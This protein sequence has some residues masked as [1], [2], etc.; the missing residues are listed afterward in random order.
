[1][2]RHLIGTP[3]Q[4]RKYEAAQLASSVRNSEM[5]SGGFPSGRDNAAQ[6]DF[7]PAPI[8]SERGIDFSSVIICRLDF[9]DNYR[10]AKIISPLRIRAGFQ[11]QVRLA[12]GE[13]RPAARLELDGLHVRAGRARRGSRR[14]GSTMRAF[15]PGQVG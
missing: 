11:L 6:A 9:P 3:T 5:S 8:L 4:L 2:P 10:A 12:E 14:R 13:F 1:M 15:C 7:M